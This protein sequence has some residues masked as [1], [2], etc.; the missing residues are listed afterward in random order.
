MFLENDLWILQGGN[1]NTSDK[2]KRLWEPAQISALNPLTGETRVTYPAGLTHCFPP[3]A[4][5]NF[6]FAGELDMTNLKTGEIIAN[7]ITKANCSRENG[8][9]PANGLV[10]TTPKHCTCWPMLRGF[11]A[12][13][14]ATGKSS[15]ANLPPEK[16]DFLFEKGPAEFDPDADDPQKH[17]WPLYR[18]D[19]WRSGSAETPG[20]DLLNRKWSVSLSPEP[21]PG[22]ELSGPIL[23]DWRDNPVV[24]APLSAPTVANGM[25]YV[26][27]PNAHELIAIDTSSGQVR[28]KFTA[29]PASFVA[30]SIWTRERRLTASGSRAGKP[31]PWPGRTGNRTARTGSPRVRNGPEI[32]SLIPMRKRKS[33]NAARNFTIASTPW[34]WRPMTGFSW[35]IRTVA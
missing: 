28:W 14:P 16:I 25:A 21:E 3:V 4:T 8:W 1:V 35:F 7:R 9:V 5:A 22:T 15:P 34:R 24:K 26:T 18:H 27:R 6:M 23:H 29:A 33:R 12:M 31:H 17:D 2:T 19:R 13:A 32:H 20:P 10:Y 11:V 30:T